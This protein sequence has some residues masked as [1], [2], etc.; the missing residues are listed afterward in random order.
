MIN[1]IALI[2]S[3]IPS[4][5]LFF[6]LSGMHKEDPQYRKD[7]GNLM[8]RGILSTLAVTL[9]SLVM[10]IIESLIGIEEASPVL[11]ALFYTFIVLAAS[12]ET[13]KYFTGKKAVNKRK[14]SVSRLDVITFMSIAGSGFGLAEDVLYFFSTNIG[15]ILIRGITASHAFYGMIMGQL[16]G[17]YLQSGKKIYHVLS[18]LIP[19]VIHGFYDFGFREEAGDAGAFISVTLA[20][21][22]LVYAIVM[23]FR[24]RKMK[25][26]PEYIEPLL[27]K[28]EEN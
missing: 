9:V 14:D 22:L 5:L 16:Y 18:L 19:I 7:C 6:W 4:L 15:Q 17:K 27:Q 21:G 12:E 10:S 1:V 20:A 24:I 11:A 8:I 26:D 28:T 25:K 23:I 13:V 3:F 2:V